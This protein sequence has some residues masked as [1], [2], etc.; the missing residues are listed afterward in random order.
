MDLFIRVAK[1]GGLAV[2]GREVGLSPASMSA[3]MN[4]LE[5]RYGTRLLNRSTRHVSLTETG[6]Q[7]YEA[8]LRVLADVSEVESQIVGDKDLLTGSLRITVSSDIGRQHIATVLSQFVAIHPKVT[9]YLHLTDDI[10]NISEEGFDCAIRHGDLPDSS[11]VARKLV[12]NHRVLCAS[13]Q[14]L[15]KNGTP[16]KPDELQKHDCL[17][18]T[19]GAEPLTNWHLQTANGLE[20]VVIKSKRS[21]NDGAMV[22]QWAIEGAGIALKSYLEV[23]EDIK[24]KRL[25]VILDDYMP[26]FVKGKA[27]SNSADLHVIYPSRQ[28][29]PKRVKAF[30]E[31]LMRY[32]ETLK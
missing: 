24:A 21:S 17:T 23:A 18:M 16:K 2:A 5:A 13:P 9:P 3:R 20:T 8:S 15:K 27:I 26:N 11:L 12:S 6:Q 28:Y 4:A 30:I 1:N 19:R 32:F 14:Y 31:A 25:V 10:V 29:Q 7:F 22:R